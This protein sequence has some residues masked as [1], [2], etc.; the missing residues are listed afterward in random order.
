MSNKTQLQTNNT[1]LAFCTDRVTALIDMANGLP[2]AGGSVETCTVALSYSYTGDCVLV[3][4]TVENNEIIPKSFY[5]T[6]YGNLFIE[7]TFSTITCVK[8]SYIWFGHHSDATISSYAT[9]SGGIEGE[10]NQK[11]YT[12]GMKF[13][14]TGDGSITI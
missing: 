14:V 7:N 1:N 6:N 2:E 8:D 10:T 4:E 11:G 13:K 9:T 12:C 5:V 3:W